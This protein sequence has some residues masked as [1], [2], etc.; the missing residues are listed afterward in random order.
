[1]T[2]IRPGPGS[3]TNSRGDPAGPPQDVTSQAWET[4]SAWFNAWL[5]ADGPERQRLSAQLAAEHPVL[6]AAADELAR[7]SGHL[8]DF[9][10]T[11]ALVLAARRVAHEDLLLAADSM[12]GPYRVVNLIARG[13]MGD[14]Y[15]AT[16]LRL[17]RDVAVK[18]LADTRTEDP[19]RLDRFMKEARATASLDHPNVVRVYDVGRFGERTYLVAELLE[20]ETLRARIDRGPMPAEEVVRIAM[21][22]VGGLGAAHDAGLVHRDLKPE[23]I[24]LTRSGTVKILD[25]GIAKLS[26]D[27]T[28]AEG[29]ST[30]T[31]VV[32]GTA[33]YLAPEQIRGKHVDA[34]A[35]L[36]AV[37]VVLFE[38]LTGTRAF[39][40]EHLVETL[41]AIL[42]EPPSTALAERQ[43]VPP[44]LTAIV[45]RLLEKSPES[46]FRSCADLI[47]ALERVDLASRDGAPVISP[48]PSRKSSIVPAGRVFTPGRAVVV[49]LLLLTATAL[50]MWWYTRRPQVPASAPGHVTLAILPF[51]SIPERSPDDLLQAGLAE[52]LVSRLS[53]LSDVRV[54]PLSASER[55]RGHDRPAELARTLGATYVLAGTVQR[56]ERRVRAT[57]QL[58]RAAD[59]R[60][61]WSAP[62]DADSSSVFSIQDIIVTRVV[63]ELSP[64]LAAGS[65][66]GLA[67]PGTR[68]NDAYE[69][70]LRGLATVSK[71]TRAELL[72]AAAF[73]SEAVKLDPGFADAWAGLGSA[74]KRLTIGGDTRPVDAFEPAKRAAGTGAEH[75]PRPR[76]GSFRARNG[77]VLVRLGLR[78]SRASAPAGARTPAQLRRRADLSGAPLF[79]S[80][81]A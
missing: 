76:R 20:G 74:Y 53:H 18:V 24:F 25:F 33:G 31:G 4:L 45:M 13:G 69:A 70:Y 7:S 43:D 78:A 3:T 57:V 27:D 29:L 50:G 79:E 5:A 34:S 80:G 62:I 60:T 16:D 35:D 56:E 59:D 11:P 64:R 55:L 1:M 17:Q 15:R 10:E 47:Q 22:M 49:A 41:Y 44:E 42:H 21:Q 72:R 61:V 68:N 6:V 81:P 32:L 67:D 58:L 66:R 2:G 63:A 9:L 36:F 40:R 48:A 39:V 77:S 65:R 19:L 23:N 28:V 52:V 71:A 12:I 37:G 46:R 14:V 30:L 51:K 38:A 75:R 54:L 73:F 8:H 26:Q